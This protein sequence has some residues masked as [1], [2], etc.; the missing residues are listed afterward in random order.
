MYLKQHVHDWTLTLTQ[1]L[2]LIRENKFM[3]ND[4]TFPTYHEKT[5]KAQQFSISGDFW[6]DTMLFWSKQY[7]EFAQKIDWI[8]QKFISMSKNLK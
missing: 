6:L 3:W 8:D 5:K 4:L 1:S 7:S 2:A